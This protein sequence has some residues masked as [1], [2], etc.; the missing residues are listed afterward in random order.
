MTHVTLGGGNV[1]GGIRRFVWQE[2]VEILFVEH[3]GFFGRAG[4]YGEWGQDY[5]DNAARFAFFCQSDLALGE[6]WSIPSGDYPSARLANIDV[7]H[8]LEAFGEIGRRG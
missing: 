7:P 8:D 5:H 1:Y 3:E 6:V 2:N 4:L